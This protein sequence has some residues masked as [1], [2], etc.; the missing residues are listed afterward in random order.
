MIETVKGTNDQH[1]RKQLYALLQVTRA[2]NN[3]FPANDLF[4]IY[5]YILSHQLGFTKFAY[6]SFDGVW[7][8]PICVGAL[9]E[10]LSIRP[11]VDLA[12]FS[13]MTYLAEQDNPQLKNFDLLVPIQ[14]KNH[15]LAYL[16]IGEVDVEQLKSARK[17]DL[18]F[19][20]TICNIIAVAIENKRLFK[21]NIQQ[22]MYRR[23]LEMAREVQSMLIP[24]SLPNDEIVDFAAFYQPQ[25]Q[26]G[27]DYYD[28]I[29]MSETELIFCVA[30]VSGKGVS[31][32][33]LMA[34]FQ[35]YLR[36]MVSNQ[37]DLKKL[38]IDLND[39]VVQSA[40]GEKFI[41]LFI[42]RYNAE[43]RELV[44]VNA[45]HN[46][47]VLLTPKGV[48]SLNLG[49]TGLGMI[50]QLYR[51]ESGSVVLPPASVLVCYTD[52]LVEQEDDEGVDFGMEHLIEFIEQHSGLGSQQLN[53]A[54]VKHLASFKGDQPYI[55]DIA[56]LT[57]RFH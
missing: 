24:S 55:D 18:E 12:P 8:W 57:C 49:T 3:N 56:L 46:P 21:E 7:K 29:R 27:G 26:V 19:I 28:C 30:D 2:I 35:A 11:E 13:E 16:L 4:S 6:C 50:E 45:G 38:V 9:H 31:A 41:T 34:N 22:E 48:E 14:H 15:P 39:K 37:P 17:F 23:E 51:L 42:A 40:K 54:L 47:P 33:I 20:Q 44:Y 25:R 36:A 53:E 10:T 32:A 52:G 43:T 1:Y 5:E